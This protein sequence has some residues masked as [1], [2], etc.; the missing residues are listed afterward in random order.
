MAAL[1]AA[2]VCSR[3]RPVHLVQSVTGLTEGRS[4]S[5]QL[6]D[7]LRSI[8]SWVAVDLE[9][10]RRMGD[11]VH[12]AHRPGWSFYLHRRH[13]P[14]PDKPRSG[15]SGLIVTPEHSGTHV[16]AL[17]HQALHMR[18]FGDIQIS[19]QN[20]GPLGMEALSAETVPALVCRGI[21]LDLAAG[22]PG[23]L[24]QNHLVTASEL[25]ECESRQ[26]VTVREG[27]VVL[28]RTGY[29][30]LW[31]HPDVYLRA[32]GLGPAA[33]R[34]LAERRVRAVGADNMALDVIGYV[35]PDS[36]LD[37]PCHVCLLVERGIYIL[38]NLDLE[39]LARL[40][41]GVF[42]FICAPLKIVGG[43]GS[44]VRPVALVPRALGEWPEL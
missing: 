21:L 38:E 13:E 8:E 43:T 18:L 15:A 16:D 23:P 36:G 39:E 3:T 12:P 5:S 29:G 31:M 28:V 37:L 20:Q 1:L 33:A 10:P 4:R 32:A 24:A 40:R 42:L 26:G 17:C 30:G 34:W 19:S 7:L 9:H 11:Q 27:D 2:L 22:R 44:P 41:A 6:D 14:R 25:S 35:D